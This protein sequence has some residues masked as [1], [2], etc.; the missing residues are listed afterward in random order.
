MYLKVYEH[1]KHVKKQ[2]FTSIYIKYLL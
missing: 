1:L 2:V